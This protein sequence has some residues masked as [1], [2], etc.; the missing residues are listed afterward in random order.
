MDEIKSDTSITKQFSYSTGETSLSFTL[1]I[2]KQD[3][4]KAFKKILEKALV[5]VSA[6]ITEE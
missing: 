2:E 4:I 1:V 6:E 3:Q 5:D